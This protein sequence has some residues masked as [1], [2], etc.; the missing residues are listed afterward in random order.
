MQS[1]ANDPPGSLTYMRREM[2]NPTRIVDSGCI[3]DV[4]IKLMPSE[5]RH[6]KGLDFR[7]GLKCCVAGPWVNHNY[8]FIAW[9]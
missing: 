2:R 8:D 5:L 7:R 1:G 4:A 9:S 6:Q 3:M